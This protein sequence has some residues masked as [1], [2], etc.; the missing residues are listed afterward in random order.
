MKNM[1]M[2]QAQKREVRNYLK[3][4]RMGQEKLHKEENLSWNLKIVTK[5]IMEE[6]SKVCTKAQSMK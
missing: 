1:N 5:W 3:R 6:K 2:Y 4:G